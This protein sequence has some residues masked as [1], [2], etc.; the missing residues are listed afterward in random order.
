MDLK[1]RLESCKKCTK[2]KFSDTGIIYSLT[3]RKPDFVG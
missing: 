1:Q 2:I 3:L